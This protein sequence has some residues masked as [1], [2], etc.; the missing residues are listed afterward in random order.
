M[1][2]YENDGIYWIFQLLT[3]NWRGDVPYLGGEID[4]Y[5]EYDF[6]SSSTT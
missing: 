4:D 2:L 3:E 1:S 6:I 5:G